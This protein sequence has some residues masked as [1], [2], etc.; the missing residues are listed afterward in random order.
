MIFATDDD[1]RR[2]QWRRFPEA[3]EHYR[4]SNIGRVKSLPGI[5][6]NTIDARYTRRPLDVVPFF[7]NPRFSRN[8]LVRMYWGGTAVTRTLRWVVAKTWV[9]NPDPDNL[10]LASGPR[11]AFDCRAVNLIWET[12]R[13]ESDYRRSALVKRASEVLRCM[14]VAKPIQRTL[15]PTRPVFAN[16][17]PACKHFVLSP[18]LPQ[19][20]ECSFL[21]QPCEAVAGDCKRWSLKLLHT[22]PEMAPTLNRADLQRELDR[23]NSELEDLWTTA[24]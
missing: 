17:C 13:D 20:S 7:G 9:T 22:R 18:S 15:T 11:N 8:L 23:I 4:V 21:G 2:E 16:N 14:R 6:W 1:I 24:E 3:P 10:T 5:H 19:N 12:P